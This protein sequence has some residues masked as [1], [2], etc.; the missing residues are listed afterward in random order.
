MATLNGAKAIWLLT[1]L[2]DLLDIADGAFQDNTFAFP[3][4]LLRLSKMVADLQ[5]FFGRK[6]VGRNPLLEVRGST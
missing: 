4:E 5:P 1:E 3:R 2:H 6:L